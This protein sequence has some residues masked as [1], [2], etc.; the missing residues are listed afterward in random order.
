MH[1]FISQQLRPR[2]VDDELSKISLSQPLGQ[3]DPRRPTAAIDQLCLFSAIDFA[4][5]IVKIDNHGNDNPQTVTIDLALVCSSGFL[6]CETKIRVGHFPTS[7][8]RRAVVAHALSR[9]GKGC[10]R[11]TAW[12]GN[13]IENGSFTNA[14]PS[15]MEAIFRD[16]IDFTYVVP[17]PALNA[18]T[19]SNGQEIV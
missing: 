7:R 4:P 11:T 2:I 3:R 19:K 14:G 1:A 8:T 5:T 12:T 15:A 10:V 13:K 6:A 9:Q 16:S 18:Y 17:G